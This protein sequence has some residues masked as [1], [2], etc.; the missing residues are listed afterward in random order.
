MSPQEWVGES[1]TDQPY[2]GTLAPA[3]FNHAVQSAV[4]KFI[5]NTS[6]LVLPGV[7]RE[8]HIYVQCLH[9]PGEASIPDTYDVTATLIEQP[10][11]DSSYIPLPNPKRRWWRKGCTR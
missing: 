9:T 7:A 4:D 10:L 3:M 2:G 6:R 1:H 11:Q 8:L 5:T